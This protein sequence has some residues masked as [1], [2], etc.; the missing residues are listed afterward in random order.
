MA[1]AGNVL[2]EFVDGDGNVA[3]LKKE[4]A[5]QAGEVIDAAV[6]SSR[7]LAR[8]LRGANAGCEGKGRIVF[9]AFEGD[10]D[11]GF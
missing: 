5:V 2:I 10:D 6:M 11:E 7:G 4:T 1:E 8:F 3:V 9:V